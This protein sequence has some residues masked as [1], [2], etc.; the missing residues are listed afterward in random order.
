MVPLALRQG[1][2]LRCSFHS[3]DHE[4]LPDAEE[5]VDGSQRGGFTCVSQYQQNFTMD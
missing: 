1:F 4:S 2:P 3:L 5:R